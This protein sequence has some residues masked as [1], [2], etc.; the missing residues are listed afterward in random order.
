[1]DGDPRDGLT[2]DDPYYTRALVDGV[3]V[4]REEIDGIIRKAAEHWSLERM[5]VVDRNVLRIGIYELIYTD[6]PAGV[7]VDQAVTLAKM[8]STEDSGRFVNGL[9]GR[10]ASE[11]RPANA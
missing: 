5:P 1:M 9:L 2:H 4:H 11:R 3:T 8:L 10:V 7:I 6:V